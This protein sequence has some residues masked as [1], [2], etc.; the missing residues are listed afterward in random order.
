MYKFALRLLLSDWEGGEYWVTVFDELATKFLGLTANQY[1]A[2]PSETERYAALAPL[3]ESGV[4]VTI[5]KCVTN[6]YVN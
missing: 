2:V 4:M 6:D 1:M 3:R 5:K